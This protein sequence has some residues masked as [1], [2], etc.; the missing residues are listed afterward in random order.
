[1]S[2]APPPRLRLL[3]EQARRLSRSADLAPMLAAREEVCRLGVAM[4]LSGAVPRERIRRLAARANRRLFLYEQL[5]RDPSLWEPFAVEGAEHLL[6]AQ[7]AGRGVIVSPAHLGRYRWIP[8]AFFARGEDV[9][10]LVDGPTFDAVLTQVARPEFQ[11]RFPEATRASF[12]AVSSLSP[13]VLWAAARAL[14]RGRVLLMFADGNTGNHGHRLDRSMI[15]LPFLGR[16][17]AART[18]IA[19]LAAH[20]GAPIVPVAAQERA[21]RPPLLSFAAPIVLAP[22]EP[23]QRFRERATRELFGWLERSILAAPG[24]WEEWSAFTHWVIE[25]LPAAPLPPAPLPLSLPALAGRRL[26]LAAGIWLT[27]A[28][29]RLEVFDTAGLRWLGDDAALVELV[30]AAEASA[31]ALGWA[32]GQADTERACATLAA[33]IGAGLVTIPRQGSA[34]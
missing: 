25:P 18:G 11:R 26:S 9:T 19:A 20:T 17:I 4:A 14:N 33:A 12:E 3:R 13:G 29:G 10:L 5:F 28:R 23:R 27:R 16:T 31:P 15:T 1:M 32:L 24:A 30:G 8:Q 34:R 21:G 7:A 22:D 6:S 2:D